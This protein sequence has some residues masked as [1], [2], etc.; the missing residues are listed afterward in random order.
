[1]ILSNE[2]LVGKLTCSNRPLAK[3]IPTTDKDINIDIS[4]QIGNY[5]ID[6]NI[7]YQYDKFVNVNSMDMP[8]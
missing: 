7:Y 3:D 6:N 5:S 4:V 2:M 1:M 8:Y